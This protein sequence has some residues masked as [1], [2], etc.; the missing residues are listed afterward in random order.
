MSLRKGTNVPV[1]QTGATLIELLISLVIGLII[2]ASMLGMYVTSTANSSQLLKS[3]KLN[4]ELTTLMTVMIN[5][6]RRAGYWLNSDVNKNA[7]DN[8][9]NT[10]DTKITVTISSCITYAYE[11]GANDTLDTTDL[12]G[13]RLNAGTAE[14]EMRQ[15]GSIGSEND[16]ADGIWLPLTDESYIEITELD[17]VLSQPPD[18]TLGDA[19][20]ETN[21]VSIRLTG[22]LAS[23]PSAVVTLEQTVRVRNDRV[24]IL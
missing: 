7:S 12:F 15:S 9:F 5:D 14:V 8:P 11:S 3:S 2:A 24:K 4:Q 21:M 18:Y 22:A 6:I 17:F 1:K 20:L 10:E 19:A 16:C 13:F 23:D